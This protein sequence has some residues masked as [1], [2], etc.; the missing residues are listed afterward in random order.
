[1]NFTTRTKALLAAACL[2]AGVAFAPHALAQDANQPSG[3]AV[4]AP[5]VT[6]EK[7]ES[8]VVAFNEVEQVKQ[9]YTQQLQAAESPEEQKQIQNEAGQRM[10]QAVE[11]TDGISIDEYNQ[12][13]Q[14]AQADPDL[15]QKL[16][17]AI[18]QSRQ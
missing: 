10:L 2:S 3:S 8:F 5:A 12:I 17:D 9:D 14:T 11:D 13:L 16:T 4:E 6:D 18:G 1:M 7:L 15:A